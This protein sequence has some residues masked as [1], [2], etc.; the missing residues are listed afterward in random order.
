AALGAGCALGLLLVLAGLTGRP[1]LDGMWSGARQRIAG[2]DLVRVTTAVAAFLIVT[3]VTGWIVGGV[4]AAIG[5]V[6][7]PRLLGG[8]ASRQ[9][10]IG[11]TEAVASWTEM[12]RD[13]IVAA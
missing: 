7:V 3:A 4:L 1:L 11:R 6:A 9:R 5:A 13:S 12:I 2:P 8:K 10:A